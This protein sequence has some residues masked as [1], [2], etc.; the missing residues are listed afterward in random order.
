MNVRFICSVFEAP[1]CRFVTEILDRADLGYYLKTSSC[2]RS[3]I[4]STSEY[5]LHLAA[6]DHEY[7]TLSPLVCARVLRTENTPA[8][9]LEP[10]SER[11][12]RSPHG[13]NS[14]IQYRSIFAR[15]NQ[16]VS[17]ATLEVFRPSVLNPFKLIAQSN[18]CNPDLLS[19]RATS[20]Q[21][22]VAMPELLSKLGEKSF[23]PP[24]RQRRR[25]RS[26]H[27]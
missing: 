10:A 6:Q 3:P 9:Q 14:S 13:Q 20:S 27:P 7:T 4:S 23:P 8:R 26:R 18:N 25:R 1:H 19:A 24:A 2:R 15:L 22:S 11:D 16:S 5:H 12:V 17:R 21:C